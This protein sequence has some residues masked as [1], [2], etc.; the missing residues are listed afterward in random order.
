ML[1]EIFLLKQ[2]ML[3]SRHAPSGPP[4]YAPPRHHP[5]APPTPLLL[6]PPCL[7]LQPQP[8]YN[9]SPIH[10][11][12]VSSQL[13]L[14]CSS[15]QPNVSQPPPCFSS[16]QQL[17]ADLSQPL[18]AS[19]SP[20]IQQPPVPEPPHQRLP[21]SPFADVSSFIC[22]NIQSMTPGLTVRAEEKSLVSLNLSLPSL[23]Y[24]IYIPFIALTE[25]WLTP[26]T[27]DAQISIPQYNVFKADRITRGSHGGALLYIHSD[28]PVTN[29]FIFSDDHCSSVIC[30]L[31]S[32][33]TIVAS[34]RRKLCPSSRPMSQM[35]TQ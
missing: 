12:I 31:N 34:I 15:Q 4:T 16:S 28:L 17:S 2:D 21:T 11:R 19:S 29:I 25:T 35:L 24:T 1:K 27:T 5:S 3:I 20:G 23:A 7:P 30:T 26:F 10:S 32:L 22:L 18:P 13:P 6:Q 14:F 33:D 9:S 8:T